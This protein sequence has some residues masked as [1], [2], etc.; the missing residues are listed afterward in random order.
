MA[1]NANRICKLP[2]DFEENLEVYLEAY[3][4][5]ITITRGYCKLQ[6]AE[7]SRLPPSVM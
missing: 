6:L 1:I 4:G 5:F 7:E 3:I 2:E